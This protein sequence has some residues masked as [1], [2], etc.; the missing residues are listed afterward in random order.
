[1]SDSEL[2]SHC[3]CCGALLIDFSRPRPSPLLVELSKEFGQSSR[4]CNVCRLLNYR[5]IKQ[6][7]NNQPNKIKK[8][9]TKKRKTV[10][11]QL[12]EMKVET[13]ELKIENKVLSEKLQELLAENA[14]L[15]QSLSE[16]E[17]IIRKLEAEKQQMNQINEK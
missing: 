1:M 13:D 11:K 5:K 14:S 10:N 15:K 3:C 6:T 12:D 8:K 2:N 7:Q 17:E 9:N 16:K 4:I